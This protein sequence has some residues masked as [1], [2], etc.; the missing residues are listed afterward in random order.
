MT[1]NSYS[2]ENAT[3]QDYKYNGKEEQTELGLGW[4]DYGAR[5]YQPELGKFFTQ[6][7]FS[8]KYYPL[9]PYQYAANNPVLNIDVNGDSIRVN[10]TTTVNGQS[11]TQAYYYSY[12]DDQGYGFYDASGARY[13][14]NDPFIKQVNAG[15]ARLGLGKEGGAM[16]NELM[17][18][19]NM[20][21]I[22][23]STT[24]NFT[25]DKS[26]VT[27]AYA[28]QIATDP[29]YSH[30]TPGKGGAGGVVKWDPNGANVWVII[31]PKIW[32]TG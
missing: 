18:S 22:E 30:L 12:T 2:R 19:N 32:T 17:T 25:E 26:K 11:Q 21:T 23:Q 13:Q 14:G 28:S 15:L 31:L 8:E 10:V 5:M 24:N 6:D 16:V 29:A 7:R 27:S 20:F 4:L 9:S 1:Y 3:P